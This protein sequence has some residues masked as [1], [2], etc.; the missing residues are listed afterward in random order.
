[1]GAGFREA[2]GNG[3]ESHPGI[4]AHQQKAHQRRRQV[5]SADG[6]QALHCGQRS[7]SRGLQ[8]EPHG[9]RPLEIPPLV[10]KAAAL[11]KY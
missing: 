9:L 2:A 10:H 3:E 5:P 6:R 7:V 8:R 1:M 4:G 11:K